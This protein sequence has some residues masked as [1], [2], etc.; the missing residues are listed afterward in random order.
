MR[1]PVTMTSCTDAGLLDAAWSCASAGDL[2][3]RIGHESSC[4]RL[5]PSDK[6]KPAG[7]FPDPSRQF[8]LC[9]RIRSAGDETISRATDVSSRCAVPKQFWEKRNTSNEEV[10]HKK[11]GLKSQFAGRSW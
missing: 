3:T 10:T 1:E 7:R 4:K 5:Q 2:V 11:A 9:L 8:L 6:W